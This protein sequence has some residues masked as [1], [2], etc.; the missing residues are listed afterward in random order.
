MQ[1]AS[2]RYEHFR[3]RLMTKIVCTLGPSTS[4]DEILESMIDSGMSVARL[5]LSHGDFDTH[6]KDAK[7]VRRLSQK[8]NV[9]IGIM[10]DIPGAKYRIGQIDHPIENIQPGDKITLSSNNNFQK[11]GY[12]PVV[13]DGI[14]LDANVGNPILINDGLMELNVLEITDRDVLCEA[15]TAGSIT[16]GRG[17]ATP[18]SPPSQDFPDEKGIECL[19]FAAKQDADFIALSTV[20][21]KRNIEKARSI[22]SEHNWDGFIVSKIERAEALKNLDEIIEA[23]D[24]IMVARGDM[25]VDVPLSKV[26]IIQKDLIERC[27]RVGKPVITATQMLES[28]IHSPIPTRA[29]VTDV[30]NAVYDG[31]D[32]VMLSGETSVG[33]YPINAVRIMA[34]TAFE[35]E[36][37]LRYDIVLD[38][39]Q[40][41]VVNKTEDALSFNAVHI[42]N[43]VNASMI[44]AFTE[45]GSTA[46]RVSKYRPKSG[47]LALTPSEK[48]Q[49][50]LTLYWGVT[51]VIVKSL[52]SLEDFFD[53]GASEALKL[54]HVSDGDNVILV[55][56]VPIGVPGGTNLLYVLSLN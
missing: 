49:R 34:E 17:V 53:Y 6:T 30:A 26:P 15:K 41:Y 5:N 1:S 51:P 45:S 46:G 44:I 18:G 25:G 23:S 31:S 35:A 27:N 47:I 16:I 19:E 29:E 39:K 54:S 28:I 38:Q 10:I 50:R 32:A 37:A 52:Q 40:S 20:T 2:F 12:I 33:E 56:G 55:A 36:S 7:R 22:L 11:T 24:A 21:C 48:S 4:A 42:A 3:D 9:P 13:P 8:L 43:S 14:H